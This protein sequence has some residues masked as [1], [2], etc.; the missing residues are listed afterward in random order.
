MSKR[1]II[2]GGVILLVGGG[3]AY[4]LLSRPSI[5]QPQPTT[6]VKNEPTL[7]FTS[8][9]KEENVPLN[10][11]PN[12]QAI[13]SKYGL[14][15][16]ANQENFLDQNKFLLVD[17]D[18]TSFKPGVNFDQMLKDFDSMGGGSIYYRKPEDTKLITPDIVLHAYHKYFELTLEQLEQ[19]ELSKTLNDF[20][21]G[22]HGNL[23][24]AARNNSGYLKERY[25]NLE[26]QIVLARVLFENKSPAKPDYFEN[27][28]QES[29]YNEQD[30]IIDSTQNAKKI[31]AKYSSDL[32]PDLVSR[33]QYDLDKIYSA[34]EVGSSPLFSQYNDD[35]KT[36]YTQ[37]TPRSHYNKNSVLRAYFRTMMYLGRSS[38]FL[39]KDIGIVD[40]NLLVKQFTIKG[41]NGIVPLDSWN[42]IMAVTGFYAGQSDDLTYNEWRDF[43]SKV[44]G[45]DAS[46][47][48]DLSSSTNIQKLTQNL[49]QLRMPKILS[50]VIFNE[51]IF[52]ETKA[53][54]LRQSLAFRIFGQRFTFDAWVLNDLTAGQEKTEVKLPSTPSALF[55]SAAIGDLKAQDYVQEFL[56]KDA[57]F[58]KD[59]VKGFLTKLD[60]KKSDISKVK[61]DEWFNSMGSAWLYVLGALTHN[62]GENYPRYMQAI[63]FLDKQIQT[64]LGSYTE[65]KHDTL[66]YAKQS[67]AEIGGGGEDQPIPPIVKGFVEPNMDFWDRFNELL[68]RTE[69]FFTKND[70]FKGR[71]ALARLQE[72]K[73]NSSF[74]SDFAKKELQGQQIS[75]DDYEKL[76]TTKL[77]F[78]ADPFEPQNPD[79]NSGKVALIADIHTD[80]LKKQI[81]Y[82]ATGK[83]YLMLAVV[84]NEQTPR[85]VASMVYNHYEF[86]GD[87]GKRLTDEDWRGWIYN[88]VSKL[89]AK[90]FWYQSLSVK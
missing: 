85:V 58:N 3:V 49:N 54:L 22:L 60:Q 52:F 90:N 23:A 87:L 43:E 17:L 33:I 16:T 25:Q 65:L 13:K 73:D 27:P 81:L 1:N 6:I 59:D 47:D 31:L 50:D 61:K 57:G 2:L 21:I 68:N 84:A 55:V 19:N 56:Q 83:P 77:A 12:Y 37:F 41:S 69:E 30:K 35:L 34:D 75:D 15:L 40:S 78:M 9:Y 10:Q 51:N 14:Q 80:A 5:F 39:K 36:D 38:Y 53:D 28:D 67:Y 89:P 71:S 11:V 63:S 18:H 7:S 26:A 20:L 76:R 29:A 46:S 44:L 72:F 88:Q 42:K 4:A 62:F 86:T 70:L 74:Y 24:T 48:S 64:F 45:T 66:L 32:T 79:E 8:V 82:E